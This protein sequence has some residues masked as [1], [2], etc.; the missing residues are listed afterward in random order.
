M[1]CTYIISTT[2]PYLLVSYVSEDNVTGTPKHF[3]QFPEVNRPLG[4][5][6]DCNSKYTFSVNVARLYDAEGNLTVITTE[7]MFKFGCWV[8]HIDIIL[9]ALLLAYL[10]SKNLFFSTLIRKNVSKFCSFLRGTNAH[11][12]KHWPVM[13]T[14]IA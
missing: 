14:Y 8:K 11:I 13:M 7:N 5:R 2:L 1:S 9:Y 6:P 4:L 3:F 10:D 12:H